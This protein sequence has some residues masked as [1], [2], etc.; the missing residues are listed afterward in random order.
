LIEHPQWDE[1]D[2]N[3]ERNNIVFNLPDV[4]D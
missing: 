2:E 3:E 4:F 1:N